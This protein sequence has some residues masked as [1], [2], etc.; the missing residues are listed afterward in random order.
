[1]NHLGDFSRYTT[2]IPDEH[3]PALTRNLKRIPDFSWLIGLPHVE[4]ERLQGDVLANFPT[5][6]LDEAALLHLRQHVEPLEHPVGL[7]DERFADVKPRKDFFF[8]MQPR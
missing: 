1:M 3:L 2:I 7:G 5:V 8:K 4:I 6:L